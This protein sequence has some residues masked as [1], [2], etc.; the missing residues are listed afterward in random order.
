MVDLVVLEVDPAA[1]RIRVSRKAVIDAHEADE[2]RDYKE[3]SEAP[4]DGFSP[5]A[6]KLRDALEPRKP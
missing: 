6:S 4:A 1:R 2:L 5:L 3:R